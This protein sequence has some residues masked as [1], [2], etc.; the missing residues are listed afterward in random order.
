M[1]VK[2]DKFNIYD[3][4]KR[5]Y[6]RHLETPLVFMAAV[7][8]FDESKERYFF[9]GFVTGN[10]KKNIIEKIERLS[11]KLGLKLRLYGI[12]FKLSASTGRERI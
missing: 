11:S 9:K 1:N 6:Y 12:I 8:F 4:K 3:K 5:F 2:N 10:S 7:D